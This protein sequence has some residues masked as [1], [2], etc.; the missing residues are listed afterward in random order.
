MAKQYADN[1]FHEITD[2]LTLSGYNVGETR[3]EVQRM[4]DGARRK[5]FG[6]EITTAVAQ[7]IVASAQGNPPSNYHNVSVTLRDQSPWVTV[8]AYNEFADRKMVL[9]K[10]PGERG[11]P[12]LF[13]P[14]DIRDSDYTKVIKWLNQNGFPSVNKQLVI[15]CVQEL[16]EDNIISPV[17][18]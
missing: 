6:E 15:D 13:K 3:A 2:Q 17:K 12:N 11:N 14:R 18:A 16:C 9:E 5:K 7:P 1:E 10:P 4:I 8:F